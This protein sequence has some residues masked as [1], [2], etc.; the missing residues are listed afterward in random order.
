MTQRGPP[1]LCQKPGPM[2]TLAC[3]PYHVF[4]YRVSKTFFSGLKR[5]PEV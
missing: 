4:L 3:K 2:V 1:V 5:Q